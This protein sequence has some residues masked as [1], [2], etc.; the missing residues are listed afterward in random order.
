MIFPDDNTYF[1]RIAA[2][3]VLALVGANCIY[4]AITNRVSAGFRSKRRI[5]VSVPGR[6][7]IAAFGVSFLAL[8]LIT[9][10]RLLQ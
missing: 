1:S 2:S 10:W 6:I 4:Q 8:A 5:S 7:A 3:T 9:T